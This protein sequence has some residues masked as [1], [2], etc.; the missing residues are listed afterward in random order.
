MPHL[1][2]CPC[3]QQFAV[4]PE[5]L[6]QNVRCPYCGRVLH[7]PAPA[8][9]P[10]PAPS[11]APAGPSPRPSRRFRAV[12][13]VV[14]VI[15][16]GVGIL[17]FQ[18]LSA[19][20]EDPPA[21]QARNDGGTPKRTD[22]PPEPDNTD[23]KTTDGPVV[24][25]LPSREKISS[26]P[27]TEVDPAPA[28]LARVNVLRGAA[29][30][31]PVALD[32][33]LCRGCTAHA[34]YL[35]RN[36]SRLP[37]SLDELE[38][39]D[40]ALPGF[41]AEGRVT[42][43]RGVAAPGE[44][45]QALDTIMASGFRRLRFLDPRLRR[46]GVGTERETA[47]A[48]V[49]VFDFDAAKDVIPPPR[50]ATAAVVYPSDGQQDVPLAFAGNEVPDPI[51]E[52]T[53]KLGGFPITVTFAPRS[54]IVGAEGRLLD[55]KGREVPVWFSSPEKPAN[56]KYRQH[57]GTSLCLIAKDV[58]EPGATYTVRASA[59]VNGKP[60]SRSWRF[61]TVAPERQTADMVRRVLDRINRFRV[62]AGLE[63]LEQDEELS[64]A[65]QAHAIYMARNAEAERSDFNPNDESPSLPG[66]SRAGQR[67]AREAHVGTAPF[68]PEA[69]FDGWLASFHYRFPILDVNARRI[70]L[71][72][73]Q[74]PRQWHAVL[75]LREGPG[76]RG[77]EPLLYPA[78]GQ[79][80]VP[81][82]YESGEQPDPIPESKDRQAGFPI[83]A[84]FP[85]RTKV[86][87]V[88]AALSLEGT[89]VPCWL[90]TPQRPVAQGFQRNT[91]C[92]IAHHPLRPAST[93]RVR[94]VA[95]V[96]G[97]PWE[98]M[99]TFRT[100]SERSEDQ[101]QVALGVV[102]KVN[103]A[104]RA[105]GLAPVALD[106]E[107]SRGCFAH[108]RYLLLNA[109]HPSTRGLGM[110]NEDAKLP[111]HTPEGRRA[112]RDSVIASGV[113]PS[114]SVEDWMATLYHRV[115]LLSPD[116]GRIGFGFVRGGPNGWINVLNANAGRGREPA[117]LFP[118]DGQK[119]VP[120]RLHADAET[121]ATVPEAKG[122]RAG[123]P[124]TATFQA[125]RAVEQVEVALSTEEGKQ[126][127][128]WMVTRPQDGARTICV[129][130]YE[131]LRP[132]THYTVKMS[133]LVG[134]RGWTEAWTFTT[135]ER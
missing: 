124:I 81:R 24:P 69:M 12:A 92:L 117:V 80:D 2:G 17:L 8:T 6:G 129:V 113:P 7:V 78:E 65:C 9:P 3:G 122:R 105:A 88:T 19:T 43:R 89:A 93:Y 102:A 104:R 71:G 135:A 36:A 125:G 37:K 51:P 4:L 28:V 73:A 98:K 128:F 63:P 82:V 20:P 22:S 59:Q 61:T 32:R 14:L 97:R 130:P 11:P 91:V 67:V 50:G 18:H 41:S 47:G 85:A 75:R 68:E 108:A 57:Q 103:A 30:L 48:G 49:S 42:A 53:R 54:A 95:Q 100:S 72:C 112:G 83:T 107:L 79:Q 101:R 55:E 121:L 23:K 1:F 115:P 35:A 120:L 110:H 116:L 45:L 52:A 87:G 38:D 66:F 114:A 84:M 34:G 5:T 16:A 123:F 60:W 10:P 118:G 94:V 126:V 46:I 86:D 33:G 90:S 119:D 25:T 133:A 77:R 39:E 131:P 27:A 15:A 31:A 74:G 64:R 13:A 21:P 70:G 99:W 29:G 111:G 106:L 76:G 40:A 109:G 62:R 44:P 127:A 134:G 132:A 96:D 26:P 56:P 58:L